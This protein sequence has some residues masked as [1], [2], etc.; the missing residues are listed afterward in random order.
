MPLS[1]LWPRQP[2]QQQLH[3][4][5]PLVPRLKGKC[6]HGWATAWPRL[7][8]APSSSLAPAWARAGPWRGHGRAAGRSGG[9]WWPGR[10]STAL[11]ARRP[12]KSKA[13]TRPEGFTAECAEEE[14]KNLQSPQP[15]P[16]PP[17]GC[18]LFFE[19]PP[20]GTQGTQSRDGAGMT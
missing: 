19:A 12:R 8:W 5:L 7:G 6:R 17:V 20:R 10:V 16:S 3:C 18:A 14:E 11:P 1:P 4:L 9:L 15:S 13:A 2:P